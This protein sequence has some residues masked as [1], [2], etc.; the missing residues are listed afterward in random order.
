MIETV[1]SGSSFI[2]KVMLFKPDIIVTKRI[3][4][5]MNGDRGASLLWEIPDMQH[6]PVILYEDNGDV[7]I[8]SEMI[9]RFGNIYAYLTDNNSHSIQEAVQHIIEAKE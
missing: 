9:N 4:P 8:G 1:D 3:L 2:K 7:K 5:G 6:I